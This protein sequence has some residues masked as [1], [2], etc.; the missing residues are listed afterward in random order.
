MQIDLRAETECEERNQQIAA[1]FQKLAHVLVEVPQHH[2]DNDRQHGCNEIE[3]GDFRQARQAQREHRHE[4]PFKNGQHGQR[5]PRSDN[6]GQTE[7]VW[8]RAEV[9]RPDQTVEPLPGLVEVERAERGRSGNGPGGRVAFRNPYPFHVDVGVG[10]EHPECGTAT[11]G[12][13]GGGRDDDVMG[14]RQ[15]LREDVQTLGVDSIVVRYE[16][17]HPANVP[18]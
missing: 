8:I 3:H 13:E 15:G 6:L 10:V 1:R 14:V 9:T 16:N 11:T 18:R 12:V 7:A 17:P 5:A 4:W 2:A